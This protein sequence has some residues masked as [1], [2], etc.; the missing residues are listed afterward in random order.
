MGSTVKW[1]LTPLTVRWPKMGNSG[2]HKHKQMILLRNMANIWASHLAFGTLFSYHCFTCWCAYLPH[3]F[4]EQLPGPNILLWLLNALLCITLINLE[5][6][7]WSH[8]CYPNAL[9]AVSLFP[10]PE[11]E[12]RTEP[13]AAYQVA[14]KAS[15]ES[16]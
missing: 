8:A 13:E 14:D 1:P 16:T 6:F 11:R 10:S 2:W 12:C 9:F 15:P 4:E 5:H 3:V 7:A